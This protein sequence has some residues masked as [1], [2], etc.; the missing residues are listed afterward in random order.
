MDMS[1]TR[2][3]R[4]I[5]FIAVSADG[6]IARTDGDIGWLTDPP[7][8]PEHLPGHLGPN[9]PP[10]YE[11]LFAAVDHVVMGR[12]TYEKVITFGSWPY[13][14][15]QVI[16]LST[17]LE[18]DR[19]N[20]ITVARDMLAVCTLLDWRAARDVYVDGGRVIQTFLREDLVD[21]LTIS[22]APVLLGGGLP[23]FG[24]LT[25]DIR[26]THKG[27]STSDSGMTTSRYL[28]TR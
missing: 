13:E 8:N 25:S 19:D 5:V 1:H 3:W 24:E 18:S 23:L 21:E 6:Y 20:R 17:K 9:P 14:E 11:D 2:T 12:G 7:T 16:V 4:G 15:K 26:L 28:V 27:S 22:T 10:G